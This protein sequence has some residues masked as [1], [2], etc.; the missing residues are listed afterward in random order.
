MESGKLDEELSRMSAI[1][2]KLAPGA[3]VLFNESF[4]ATNER[5]GSEIAAQITQALLERGVKV[6]FV[7]HLY[8]FARSLHAKRMPNA[9]FLRAERRP[10]GTR[11][12]RVTEGEP[13][14]TSY[15]RDLYETVFGPARPS[16]S[17]QR[18]T[19][20]SG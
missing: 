18:A 8:E 16:T 7:T 9:I 14:Q 19:I 17:K 15:G 1:V 10:D 3:M 20:A 4:A 12:F 11:T 5:E 6:C 13:L 2:D